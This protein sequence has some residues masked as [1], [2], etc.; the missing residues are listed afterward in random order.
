MEGADTSFL[1]ADTGNIEGW[2]QV[3]DLG[4]AF[5]LSALIG[6][7]REARQKS[8]GLRTYTLVGVGAALFTL[9]SKYGFSDVLEPGRLVLD[10]S[11]VAAQ[12]VSGIG[13]LGAGI[14]F[15]RHGSVHGLT[16][17]AAVW[18]TAAVGATAGADL[19]VLAS[20]TTGIYFVVAIPLRELAGHLP[21]SPTA[22]STVRARYPDGRGI[23][24]QL[25]EE[26]TAQGFTIDHVFTASGGHRDHWDPGEQEKIGRREIVEVT[27]EVHGKGPVD[28]LAATLSE[29]DGVEAFVSEDANTNALGCASSSDN[30]RPLAPGCAHSRLREACPRNWR[31]MSLEVAHC[32]HPLGSFHR[33]TRGTRGLVGAL[34]PP[35][36]EPLYQVRAGPGTTRFCWPRFGLIGT[37]GFRQLAHDT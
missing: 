28:K 36:Q 22:V 3:G 34:F 19:P 25:L 23:L 16:T 35:A 26:T 33:R 24:R 27:L 20:V 10:P 30:W 32:G 15:M 12:I 13:F 6:L 2:A 21:R 14:I 17:A 37:P 11:R 4:L 9:L 31:S 29:V 8:A 5:V 18:L 1:I 7:E